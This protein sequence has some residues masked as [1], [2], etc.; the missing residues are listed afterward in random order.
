VESLYLFMLRE[1]K[2]PVHQRRS[3]SPS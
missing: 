2:R 3:D 1:Q